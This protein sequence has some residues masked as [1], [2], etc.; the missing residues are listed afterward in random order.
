[1]TIKSL[2]EK[3]EAVEKALAF[4]ALPNTNAVLKEVLRDLLL[5]LQAELITKLEKRLPAK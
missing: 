1:M 2:K 4:P 3:V 5:E